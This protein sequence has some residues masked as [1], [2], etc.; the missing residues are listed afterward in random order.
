MLAGGARPD[1]A[2]ILADTPVKGLRPDQARAV[3]DIVHCRTAAL[4]GHLYTCDHCHAEVPLY[5]SCRNRHCPQCQSLDQV[6]WV[7]AQAQHLLPVPYFH[8]V[9]TIPRELHPFFLLRPR[10]AYGLLL[11]AAASTLLAVSREEFGG[12]PAILAVLH[13]WTQTL[14]LHPHVHCIVTG[15]GVSL[16][17]QRWISTRPTFF[18]PVRKLSPV[19]RGKLLHALETAITEGDMPAPT[20]LLRQ[21][22]AHAWV[23]YCKAPMAGPQQVLAYLGRYTHRTAIGNERLLAFQDG[24]V[25]FRYR[26]RQHHNRSRTMTLGVEEFRRRVLLHVLPFHFVRIR[27]SGLLALG[28]RPARLQQARRLLDAPVPPEPSPEKESWVDLYRRLTGRDPTLC[29]LCR[30]G[31]LSYLRDLEPAALARSP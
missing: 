29:P 28:V 15:G 31:T 12:V 23:V 1:L 2:H 21:A 8:L 9:F 14:L 7:E 3:T 24:Q 27:H 16:D 13:T 20:T 17:G 18:L 25:T 10:L 5:N 11:K 19:F 26:D 30:Q 4:G 6:R 22:A